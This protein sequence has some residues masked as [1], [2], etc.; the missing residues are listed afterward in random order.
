MVNDRG[1]A[2]GWIGAIKGKHVWEIHPIAVSTPEQGKGLGQTLV[3]D[4]IR[5][6]RNH[7]AV[8]VW[9]GTSDET[10]SNIV[11]SDMPGPVCVRVQC[12]GERKC[13]QS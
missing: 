13:S 3:Q 6:A 2:V 8:A 11:D 12:S 1:E 9:A 5:L 4:I 10:G 7:G